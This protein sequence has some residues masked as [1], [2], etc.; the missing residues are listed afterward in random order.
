PILFLSSCN[1]PEVMPNL[2]AKPTLVPPFTKSCKDDF[3]TPNLVAPTGTLR[4]INS[5]RLLVV[6]LHL[7]AICI[8]LILKY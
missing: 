6:I 1:E 7:L 3:V 2:Y 8:K 4:F 5:S